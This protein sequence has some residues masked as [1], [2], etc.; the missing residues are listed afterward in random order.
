MTTTSSTSQSTDSPE[1]S[2][3][4][5]GPARQLGNFVNVSGD[6]G[7]VALVSSACAR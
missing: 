6:G 4:A 3:E 7:R 1:S 2:I 5:S